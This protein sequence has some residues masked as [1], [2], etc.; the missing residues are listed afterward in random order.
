MPAI[1]GPLDVVTVA[2]VKAELVITFSMD[3]DL[4]EDKIKAAIS[5]I[6][7]A[8][9]WRFYPRTETITTNSRT[10]DL[11]QYPLNTIAAV[12]QDSEV[13]TYKE[14]YWPLRRELSFYYNSAT[15]KV[16]TL[17]TGCSALTQI[18]D[19]LLDAIKRQ[20]VFLYEN[21]NNEKA[22]IPDDV[23]QMIFQFKRFTYF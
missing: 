9:N 15:Y 14:K 12:N 11:F 10:I 5:L 8:T 13:I 7:Q 17:T 20:V 2:Q 18:P 23:N 3:D 1:T 6:E 16:I 19:I 22:I 21:R 4:I